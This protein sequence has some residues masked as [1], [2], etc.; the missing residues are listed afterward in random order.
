MTVPVRLL[1]KL[2]EELYLYTLTN[3]P[4]KN[5]KVAEL[6]DERVAND[7]LVI[8]IGTTEMISINGLKGITSDQWYRNIVMNDLKY[9]VSDLLSH[10][11]TIA[12]QFSGKMPINSLYEDKYKNI[13]GI[14]KLLEVKFDDLISKTIKRNRERHPQTS[15]KNI[16]QENTDL[17]KQMQ[18]IAYLTEEQID[19]NELEKYL[20]DL[21]LNDP[22]IFKSSNQ[23]VRTNLRRLIRI[24]DYLKGKQ[25]TPN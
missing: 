8:S 13:A 18:Y 20:K 21:F 3:N 16:L 15:I 14:D 24:Y 1:R 2:K 7:E 23:T 5:I 12:K 4:T 25:K 10:A 17:E 9:N 6:D 19:F 22:E 11:P